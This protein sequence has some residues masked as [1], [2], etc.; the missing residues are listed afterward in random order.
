M[1]VRIGSY[2]FRLGLWLS[3][4][5]VLVLALLVSLGFWQ[6]HRAEQKRVLLQAYGDRPSDSPILLG[7]DFVPT[8]DWRYR[9]AQTLGTYD[10]DH[11]FL[12]DNRVYQGQVGYYVL[13]PLRLAH[14]D[15][16]VLVNRGWVPQGATR[17]DLPAL[18][19]P[20]GSAL[21]VE[22]LIDIPPEKTFVLGEGE[23]RAP[24]WPKVLQ[25]VRL[26]LQAQQLG[27]RLIPMI[28][29]LAP[30]QPAGFV[31][32]WKPVVFGPERHVGYAVQWF[33]L[34]AAWVILC[35][36]ASLR[37]VDPEDNM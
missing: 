36:W 28:L 29:L 11:Q 27:V 14:T 33:S 23:D 24:G 9:R 35:F 37:R 7:R 34:A 2:E 8:P 16:A 21:S 22:G 15:L 4:G 3:V 10:A 18:P 5:G 13:T 20:T 12:L 26:N 30:D 17:A 32:E 6:L 1:V 31:R 25:Q 19:A